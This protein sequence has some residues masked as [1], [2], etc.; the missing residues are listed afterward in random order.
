L[1]E[2]MSFLNGGVDGRMGTALRWDGKFVPVKKNLAV[3][4]RGGLS[5]VNT[6]GKKVW[7][8]RWQKEQCLGKKAVQGDDGNLCARVKVHDADVPDAVKG[9]GRY[10]PK[11][12]RLYVGKKAV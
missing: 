4:R 5:Y 9:P 8:K 7:L 6:A 1:V 2:M 3:G 11:Y 10:I 12:G